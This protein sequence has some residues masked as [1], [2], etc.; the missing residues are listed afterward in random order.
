MS[1]EEIFQDDTFVVL[2]KGDTTKLVDEITECGGIVARSINKRVT[3]V[4]CEDTKAHSDDVKKAEDAKI[5]VVKEAYVFDSVA[6]KK[7]LNPDDFKVGADD[8][9]G[10]S[11]KKQKIGVDNSVI[12][13][14]SEWNGVCISK[15]DTYVMKL[16]VKDRKDDDIEGI[17]NWPGVG[18][19]L[20]KFKGKIADDKV[21]FEEYEAVTG[22]DDVELPQYY[23]ATLSGTNLTGKMKDT[24][25]D[26]SAFKL[27]LYKKR[28]PK[29]VDMPFL[30]AGA[31]FSGVHVQIF[32]TIVNVTT[33]TKEGAFGGTIVWPSADNTKTRIEGTIDNDTIKFEEKELLSGDGVEVP[34]KYEGKYTNNGFTGTYLAT[35]SNSTGSITLEFS[36]K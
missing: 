32:P 16:V 11:T 1:K 24:I 31:R 2:S 36:K 12:A 30:I 3:V 33:R 19:A 8:Q 6:K 25:G 15:D 35:T 22:Q 14:N 26:E 23:E 13:G 29:P 18:N 20:T 28:Q 9:S 10:P 7:R 4:V 34:V 27:D 5:P 21:T 17:I